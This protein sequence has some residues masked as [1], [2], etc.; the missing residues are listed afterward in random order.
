M[1]PSLGTEEAVDPPLVTDF[2]KEETSCEEMKDTEKGRY[3][4]MPEACEV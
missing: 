1:R 2:K 4:G 3:G